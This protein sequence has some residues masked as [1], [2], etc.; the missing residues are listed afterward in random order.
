MADGA[1]NIYT[2]VAAVL[3]AARLGYVNKYHLPPAETK[4]CLENHD[5]TIGVAEDL[6]K[7][8]DALEADTELVNAVGPDLVGNLAFIKRYEFESTAKYDFEQ[9]REYYIHYI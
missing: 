7:A 2:A 9:L 1:V 3:Q 5:A 8:I 4:D 6:G